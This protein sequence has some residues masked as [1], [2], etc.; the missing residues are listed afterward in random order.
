MENAG[1]KDS[2]YS[3]AE[4]AASAPLTEAECRAAPQS[5]VHLYH[6]P[7]SLCSQK[8][9][10]ALEEKGVNWQSHV[11]LLQSY[12]QYEPDY[13]R[14][15]PRCV[16][17]ALVRDGRV[18][19]DSANILRYIDRTFGN[20]GGLVPAD[21]SERECMESFLDSADV[22]FVEAL[23]YG[24]I[25][26][27]KKP[28]M[29]N[30]ILRGDHD[31]QVMLL[32]GLVEKHAGDPFLKEA[33]GRK[34]AISRSTRESFSSPARMAGILAD[35]VSRIEAV[36]VQLAD[37]S[38]SKGGWLCSAA[39]SLADV[40][41]GVVLNRLRLIGLRTRLWDDRPNVVAYEARLRA[42]PSFRKG[43]AAWENPV[44]NILIPTLL[45]KA[46]KIV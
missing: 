30:A 29:M 45:K 21:R 25:D 44:T 7:L 35:T 32:T 28:A 8:V 19:T 24:H 33:Y 39:F 31:K 16:V 1:Y 41:W 40:E 43:V 10:Q 11:K 9:R 2:P 17:P 5:G 38:F 6:F 14:I 22:L 13:V 23:T 4:G 15:N 20:E 37:G 12:E 42:R 3:A 46:G 18:T 34:L 36:E 27:V 26:G